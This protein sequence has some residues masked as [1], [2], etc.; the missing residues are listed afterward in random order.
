MAF[1]SIVSEVQ[2]LDGHSRGAPG[3]AKATF[4]ETGAREIC[5]T[6][7]LTFRESRIINWLDTN[8]APVFLTSPTLV[9]GLSSTNPTRFFFLRIF[10]GGMI[11]GSRNVQF[12]CRFKAIHELFEEVGS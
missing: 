9:H 5:S 4:L 10:K 12:F 1:N 11:Y 8:Q 2:R 7:R 6:F 3:N